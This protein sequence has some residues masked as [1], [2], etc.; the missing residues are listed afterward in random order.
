MTFDFSA[1]TLM[2]EDNEVVF[3][4]YRRKRTENPKFNF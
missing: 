1:A 2:Q 3:L 4:E